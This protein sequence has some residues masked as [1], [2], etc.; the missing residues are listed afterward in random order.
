MSKTLVTRLVALTFK[1]QLQVLLLCSCLIAFASSSGTTCNTTV[2]NDYSIG[3]S[4][5]Q[6]MPASSSVCC[7]ACVA[8]PK[9]AAFVVHGDTCFLKGDLANGHTKVDNNAGI[10]RGNPPPFP[11]PSPPSPPSPP[12]PPPPPGYPN[13]QV[14]SVLP[15]PVIGQAQGTA[16]G[17]MHGF[18]GG[19][20]WQESDGSYTMI[21]SEAIGDLPVKSPVWDLHMKVSLWRSKDGVSWNRSTTLVNSSSDCTGVDPCGAIFSPFTAFDNATNRFYL[22][23][24]CYAT[25]G[26]HQVNGQQMRMQSAVHGRQGIA[27][28]Y[29]NRTIALNVEGV[30][31]DPLWWEGNGNCANSTDRKTCA[32]HGIWGLHPYLLLPNGTWYAVYG[33]AWHVG[34]VAADHGLGGE[35]RRVITNPHEAISWSI[36]GP[37]PKGIPGGA[38][39]PPGTHFNGPS[40]ENPILTKSQDG[41]FW[42]MIWDAMERYWPERKNHVGLSYSA[43]GIHNWT[44]A[45]YV[46]IAPNGTDPCGHTRTPYGLVAM[47]SHGKGVYAVLFTGDAQYENVCY[48][49]LENLSELE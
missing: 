38:P 10:V 40:I 36:D 5:L 7:D 20:W 2:H 12:P 21:P 13:F 44:A 29:V 41:K 4:I 26:C 23:Y 39:P 48:A 33:S 49:L 35:W 32:G 34:L 31:G 16:N 46:L 9:C 8:N 45:Q 15:Q 18:E 25:P 22:F 27:G 42:L 37:W 1:L 17:I 28:P 24:T 14:K 11:P 30:G 43:D 47:P 19:R 6:E 3:S